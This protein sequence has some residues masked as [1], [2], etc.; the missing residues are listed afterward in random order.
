MQYLSAISE[1]TEWFLFLPKQPFSVTLI[2]VYASTIN[3][4]EAEVEWFCDDQQD[5]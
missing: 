3:A 2:Q 1:M 4:E 5:L